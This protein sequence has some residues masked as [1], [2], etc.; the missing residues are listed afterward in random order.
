[1]CLLDFWANDG[2]GI[3][4]FRAAI[5]I[6]RFRFIL[7]TMR[8]DDIDT[9]YERKVMD[10]LAPIRT[11]VEDFTSICKSSYCH[12][13]NLT[14]DE[15]LPSFRGRCPF[16]IYIPSKPNKYGIKIVSTVDAKT[17]YLSNM[18]IYA[19]TQP[20]GPFCVDNSAKEVVKRLL[21]HVKGSGRNVTVDNWFTSYP[22]AQELRQQYKMTLVG[23]IRK[24]KR[25]IPAQFVATRGRSQFSSIFGHQKDVT[26]VS[27]I[28]KKNKNVTLLSTKHND[29]AIDEDT[30][31]QRK[32][33]M[34]TFYN[35]TKGGVDTVDQLCSLYG[36]E[37]KTRRWPMV[38]F[39]TIL[40]IA[41]VNAY[42]TFK[43]NGGTVNS[44]RD[45][46]K[47]LGMSLIEDQLEYRRNLPGL[48]KEIKRSIEIIRP[49]PE[50]PLQSVVMDA[51]RVRCS[52]CPRG[53]DVKTKFR[54]TKCSKAVCRNHFLVICTE[55]SATFEDAG[56]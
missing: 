37:R 45:F 17:K 31:E 27:Y 34:I 38:I 3:E 7:Q 55:C 56:E 48:A 33:K 43:S 2:T 18:E 5:S 35:K 51:S 4:L 20:T 36:V 46:I 28:P 50:E 15:M 41:G 13:N 19:G 29:A 47:Q 53:K 11:F 39:Y 52:I 14:I 8:F 40:N 9:R 30:G 6:T 26:L 16:K 21:T 32:P 44:R 22:L 54:C 49:S 25:E 23:T 24:N 10:K 12:S 1:M 42:V